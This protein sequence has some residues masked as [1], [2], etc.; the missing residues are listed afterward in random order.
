MKAFDHFNFRDKNVKDWERHTCLQSF[1]C[2]DNYF[3]NICGLYSWAQCIF[4][5]SWLSYVC[6]NIMNIFIIN[7]RTSLPIYISFRQGG[8]INYLKTDKQKCF[9]K[10]NKLFWNIHSW[11]QTSQ[12]LQ[13]LSLSLFIQGS[14]CY[15]RYYCSQLSKM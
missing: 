3:Y 7:H 11:I 13:M 12:E 1:R 2:P 15:F 5:T 10:Y 9:E 8:W 4:K 14:Q 6:M